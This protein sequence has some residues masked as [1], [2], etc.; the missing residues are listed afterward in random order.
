VGNI[1][2]QKGKQ[3]ELS[4]VL[5]PFYCAKWIDGRAKEKADG[6]PKQPKASK[7]GAYASRR[8]RTAKNRGGAMSLRSK[9]NRARKTWPGLKLSRC[10]FQ[11]RRRTM[12]KIRRSNNKELRLGRL[13]RDGKN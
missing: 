7:K 3:E 1:R 11:G 2:N 4:D 12:L 9:K 13:H 10:K 8:W 6:S 5:A